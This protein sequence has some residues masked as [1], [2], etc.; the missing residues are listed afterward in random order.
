MPSAP[1]STP[2]DAGSRHKGRQPSAGSAGFPTRVLPRKALHVRAQRGQA[3][4]EKPALP[5]FC[6]GRLAPVPDH[7]VAGNGAHPSQHRAP[8]LPTPGPTFV[9]NGAH[10]SPPSGRKIPAIRPARSHTE[11]RRPQESRQSL[12][13]KT[14]K[15]KEKTQ[16]R[17][18]KVCSILKFLAPLQ[19]ET[20][21][22]QAPTRAEG[23][24]MLRP[25][26]AGLR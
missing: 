17:Q 16:K 21:R 9:H 18:P 24:A 1:S 20:L 5:A 22:S 26:L 12:P 13:Y 10:H 3:Q 14:L 7:L 11:A 23:Q 8:S 25:T 15:A 19:G 2:S 4:A 6:D